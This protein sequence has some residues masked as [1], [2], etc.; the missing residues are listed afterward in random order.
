MQ[1]K[2]YSTIKEKIKEREKLTLSISKSFIDQKEKSK[3]NYLKKIE[4]QSFYDESRD[5]VYSRAKMKN[6]N[7]ESGKFKFKRE[8]SLIDSKSKRIDQYYSKYVE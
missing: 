6:N 7:F 1:D 2:K 5:H 8:F 4:T 3:Q